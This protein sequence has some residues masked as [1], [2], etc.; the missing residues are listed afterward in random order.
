MQNLLHVRTPVDPGEPLWRRLRAGSRV[1][2]SSSPEGDPLDYSLR[3]S[4][5]ELDR[6]AA[7]CR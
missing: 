7:D 3:G 6:V 4:A 2:L 1:S 5:A